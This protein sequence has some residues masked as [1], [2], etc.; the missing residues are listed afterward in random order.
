MKF[1]T[2]CGGYIKIE[3]EGLSLGLV[4]HDAKTDRQ[5][6]TQHDLPGWHLMDKE[7]LKAEILAKIKDMLTLVDEESLRR[8]FIKIIIQDLTKAP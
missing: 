3:P 4:W 1:E 6:G 2:V 8:P 7:S 5:L